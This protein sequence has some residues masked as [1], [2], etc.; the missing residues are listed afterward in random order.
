MRRSADCASLLN[1]HLG[2]VRWRRGRLFGS[3]RLL[4]MSGKLIPEGPAPSLSDAPSLLSRVARVSAL[5]P[6]PRC[7]ARSEW[8]TLDEFVTARKG[9]RKLIKAQLARSGR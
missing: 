8:P 5:V 4:E 7:P 2:G 9:V 1:R 3:S 6:S